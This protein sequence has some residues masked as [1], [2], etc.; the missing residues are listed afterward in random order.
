MTAILKPKLKIDSNNFKKLTF[1]LSI[2][3]LSLPAC[4][5]HQ[6]KLSLHKYIQEQTAI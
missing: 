2:H 6:I 1:L 3:F 5:F 4:P